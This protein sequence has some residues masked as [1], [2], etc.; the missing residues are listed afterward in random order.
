[1]KSFLWMHYYNLVGKYDKALA[2]IDWLKQ[3]LSDNKRFNDWIKVEDI[4][5]DIYYKM[6]K[7]MESAKAYRD[8]KVVHDSVIQAQYYEDLA[9]LRTQ[10]EVD[11]LELQSKEL[12]LEAEKSTC[13]ILGVRWRRHCLAPALRRVGF[14]GLLPPPLWSPFENSKRKGGRGGPFEVSLPC[15]HEP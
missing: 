15:Q 2:I 11:K 12:E 6:G 7:G 4:R 8:S 5:A 3:T 9:K 14:P 1:M 13:Q 10:R